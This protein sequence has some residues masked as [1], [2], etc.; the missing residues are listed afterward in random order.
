MAEVAKT[1]ERAGSTSIHAWLGLKSG[2]AGAPVE[3]TSLAALCVQV[4]GDLAGGKVVMQGSNAKAPTDDEWAVTADRAGY[5]TEFTV[6]DNLKTIDTI[7][8]WLR[9]FAFGDDAMNVNVILVV[10][11]AT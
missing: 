3:F 5:S 4:T 7:P 1:F 8:R 11:E 10:R 9:P 2:Q 6:I